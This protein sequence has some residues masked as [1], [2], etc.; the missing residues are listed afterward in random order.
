MVGSSVG[1]RSIRLALCTQFVA[2]SSGSMSIRFTSCTDVVLPFDLEP[3]A[4][5]FL[6]LL[7]IF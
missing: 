5:S 6:S 7:T 2:F 3:F 1:L 4:G